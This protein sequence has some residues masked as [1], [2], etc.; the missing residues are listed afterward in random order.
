M[1]AQ[2][3]FEARSTAKFDQID[4]AL[5]VQTV[6]IALCALGVGLI[7]AALL[8]RLAQEANANA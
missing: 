6:A 3:S 5:D 7:G 8:V 4:K 2:K 1:D